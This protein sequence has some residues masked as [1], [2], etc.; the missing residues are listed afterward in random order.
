MRH[1][2]QVAH[3]S[4]GRLR[5]RVPSAKGDPA[6]LE[7]IRNALAP[8]HGVNEVIVNEAIGSITVHYD[9][10]CHVDFHR[11]LSETEGSHHEHLHIPP[12]P[13]P[14]SE[15]DEAMEMLNK[16]AE[17][18]SSHSHSAKVLFDMLRKFDAGL[19]K[20]TDNN[21][22]L[23]VLAPLGLAVYAFLELGFEAATP[24]WLTLGVFSF[25]HFVTLHA[26]TPTTHPA[27]PQSRS[28]SPGP[29][30]L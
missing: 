29:T 15:V 13:A 3:H 21:V 12:P 4:K 23:K 8:V 10:D 19:K 6:A 16:E 1:R 18:L 28:Q 5:I 24:V 20:A 9:P 11:H 7:Q 2:A 17:F 25:N 27:P 14:V 30:H 26:Q 22:D